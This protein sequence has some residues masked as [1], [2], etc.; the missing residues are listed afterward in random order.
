MTR[1]LLP[2]RTRCQPCTRSAYVLII[3]RIAYRNDTLQPAIQL[4]DVLQHILET[5][6]EVQFAF[7][8]AA[9]VED[10]IRLRC[11][12]L[13]VL[14]VAR[15]TTFRPWFHLSTLPL[16][17]LAVSVAVL[18]VRG[19]M[20]SPELRRAFILLWAR[21]TWT[22]ASAPDSC[23]LAGHSLYSVLSVPQFHHH[24]AITNIPLRNQGHWIHDGVHDLPSRRPRR[25]ETIAL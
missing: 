20:S 18:G 7:T 4:V 10:D 17:A 22:P 25:T 2:G 9:E 8:F 14:S 6:L 12:R 16:S 19:S 15:S 1:G 13:R 11:R 3:V 24:D 23:L 5:L 21:L